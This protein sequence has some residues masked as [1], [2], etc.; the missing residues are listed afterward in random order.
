MRK[1]IV[2]LHRMR[3]NSKIQKSIQSLANV[4]FYHAVL[5]SLL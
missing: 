3:F 4:I 1:A 2:E 5:D